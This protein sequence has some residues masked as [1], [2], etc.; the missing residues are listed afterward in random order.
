MGFDCGASALLRWK[1][2]SKITESHDQLK[3]SDCRMCR[4]LA[5][6]KPPDLDGSGCTLRAFPA[7][8]ALRWPYSLGMSHVNTKLKEGDDSV[9]VGICREDFDSFI[10]PTKACLKNGCLGIIGAD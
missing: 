8:E 9:I 1:H 5:T 2:I 4:L 3:Q 7:W 6:I 10:Q